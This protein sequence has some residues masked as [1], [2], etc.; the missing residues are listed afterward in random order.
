MS[1]RLT[2]Q[3]HGRQHMLCSGNFS[4]TLQLKFSIKKLLKG[5]YR[6]LFFQ[7]NGKTTLS[8]NIADN[9]GLK[10]AYLAYKS[11]LKKN[12]KDSFKLPGLEYTS[13]QLF[14]I[15]MGQVMKICNS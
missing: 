3:E 10:M 11:W 1:M 15:G 2:V 6:I 13:D 9:G 5:N 14:F 4:L 12:G 7:L 8:E